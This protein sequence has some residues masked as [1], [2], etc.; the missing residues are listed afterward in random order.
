MSD[1]RPIGPAGGCAQCYHR[2]CICGET[3]EQRTVRERREKVQTA[4]PTVI[5]TDQC[6]NCGKFA[7]VPDRVVRAFVCLNCGKTQP[8]KWSDRG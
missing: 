7:V 3:P 1:D 4:H 2:P 5:E 8:P 6:D